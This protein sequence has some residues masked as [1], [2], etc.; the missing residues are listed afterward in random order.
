MYENVYY[1]HWTPLC[2]SVWL[3]MSHYTSVSLLEMHHLSCLSY[4]NVY[5]AFDCYF[6]NLYI[7]FEIVLSWFPTSFGCCLCCCNN[8]NPLGITKSYP[9]EFTMIS[10]F[11]YQMISFG[12]RAEYPC[13]ISFLL[14]KASH[15]WK[16][17]PWLTFNSI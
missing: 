6:F 9:V 8:V 16:Q 7:K 15:S 13:C 14:D 4:C 12:H 2:T 17:I 5:N 3:L 11:F 10:Y 1:I